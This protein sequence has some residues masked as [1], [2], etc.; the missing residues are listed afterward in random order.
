MVVAVETP[1]GEEMS[2]IKQ[3]KN[4]THATNLLMEISILISE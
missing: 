1:A 3:L 2:A 4:P